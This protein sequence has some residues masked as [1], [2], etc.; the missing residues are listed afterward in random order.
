MTDQLY[1][2]DNPAWYALH[3]THKNF[4]IG[5]DG[6]KGYQKNIVAFAA[7]NT[8]I[9]NGLKQLDDLIEPDESFFIIGEMSD[10]PSNYLIERT[11]ICLQMICTAEINVNTSAN[12]IQLHET[13]ADQMAALTKLVMP[14]YYKHD[15]RLMGDY[16]GIV[17][18]DQLVAMA[19]ERIRLN[20]LTEV[21]AVV[22]HPAFT[23]RR[24]AQQLVAQ[25]V[26]TNLAAG[27]IPF[28]H[29][30]QNNERAI[31]MYEYLGFKKRRIINFTKIKRLN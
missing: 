13:E 31:R 19:G 30:G 16:F 2:L 7:W 1:K 27:N 17:D 28:L 8:S 26:N 14:G 23:G 3:E 25:V 29:T 5:I 18:D 9:N 21:S 15:T 10:L 12:I 11:I 22:T 24:Y 6:L 4:A 20:G